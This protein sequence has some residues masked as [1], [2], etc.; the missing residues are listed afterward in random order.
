MTLEKVV[1]TDNGIF[2]SD[3]NVAQPGDYNITAE[4]FSNG[5]LRD[6]VSSYFTVGEYSTE[7]SQTLLQRS[8]LENISNITGGTYFSPDSLSP[9][10]DA[11]QGQKRTS[12]KPLRIYFW[13]NIYLLIVIILLLVTEWY[14][15]KKQGL[16]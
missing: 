5:N 2:L 8:V 16:L 12:I 6:S 15:R 3:F 11:L 4:V 7:L 13:N 10:V 1:N 14:V 9:L